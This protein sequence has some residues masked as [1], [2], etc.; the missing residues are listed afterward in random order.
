ME[1]THP[2]RQGWQY[3]WIFVPVPPPK[4]GTAAKQPPVAKE[5]FRGVLVWPD[6]YP[7]SPPDSNKET[8][9]CCVLQT[10]NISRYPGSW[11]YH[12]R[13][14]K[15][16]AADNTDLERHRGAEILSMDF[17]C[18][19]PAEE[20][21]DVV[22][23]TG[24]NASIRGRIMVVRA[25]RHPLSVQHV[26]LQLDYIDVH[27]QEI[28]KLTGGSYKEVVDGKSILRPGV[29]RGKTVDEM[30]RLQEQVKEWMDPSVFS[31]EV[32]DTMASK[33]Q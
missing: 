25:G 21:L 3:P 5:P 15:W 8:R 2:N 33:G 6:A 27:L 1:N 14:P 13:S 29:I 16:P 20:V 19:R 32:N 17:D 9:R 11:E 26:R 23:D 28:V 22:L 7:R 4:P 31:K 12:S 10:G 30:R 18:S 24:M